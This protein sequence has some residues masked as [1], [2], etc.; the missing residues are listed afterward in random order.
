MLAIDG[1]HDL[2]DADQ[3]VIIKNAGLGIGITISDSAIPVDTGV[4]VIVTPSMDRINF[5]DTQ[6]SQIDTLVTNSSRINERARE[7]FGKLKITGETP[8]VSRSP[9]MSIDLSSEN[10]A[11]GSELYLAGSHLI[12][13]CKITLPVKNTPHPDFLEAVQEALAETDEK[14]R[15][16]ALTQ[17]LDQY[18]Y[19]YLTSV[20][21][22]GMK[23]ISSTKKTDSTTSI[24]SLNA[25]M[26]VV[27]KRQ[28][29][30]ENVDGELGGGDQSK[31]VALTREFEN[32]SQTTVGGRKGI[33]NPA[34]WR[35]SLDTPSTWYPINKLSIASVYTLFDAATRAKMKAALPKLEPKPR[36]APPAA[37][38]IQ[39]VKIKVRPLYRLF[40]RP[41]YDHFYTID[42]TERDN[43]KSRG[44]WSDEGVAAQLLVDHLPDSVPLY[45]LWGHGDH[46]YTTESEANSSSRTGYCIEG[47]VGYVYTSHKEGTV[48]LYRTFNSRSCDHLYT[49]DSGEMARSQG[50]YHFEH[51]QCY[52]YPPSFVP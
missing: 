39:K 14:E 48:P 6:V 32:M 49:V 4:P 25:A 50:A 40:N 11:A 17:V 2:A 10:L 9:E 33:D 27:A 18:G 26:N 52:V 12:S 20:E 16:V 8:A 21:M 43:T 29:G 30:V 23:Y 13:K 37:P 45:R 15:T 46:F 51:I 36:V 31:L 19:F 42:A 28:F 47:V 22:G 41:G 1:V 44:G 24:A 5:R 35:K 7:G 3:E 38:V 34:E